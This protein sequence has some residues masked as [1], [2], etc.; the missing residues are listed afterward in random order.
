[1]PILM[2]KF[3]N[4]DVLHIDAGNGDLRNTVKQSKDGDVL[5][6]IHEDKPV[7]EDQYDDPETDY[8]PGE[9]STIMFSFQNEKS[10]DNLIKALEHIKKSIKE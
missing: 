3:N 9:T 1:M 4:K 5:W 6:F 2:N 8:E 10:V 7:S